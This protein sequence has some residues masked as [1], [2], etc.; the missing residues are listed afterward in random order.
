MLIVITLEIISYLI[1]YLKFGKEVA[2]HAIMSKIL[3]IILFIMLFQLIATGTSGFIFSLCIYVG[4]ITK[5]E[6]ILILLI[7]KT[8]TND[9]PGLY[10]AILKDHQAEKW[11]N[12]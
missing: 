11:F 1:S 2:T 7:L 12:G 6:I 10:H 3:A 8:W 9:V 4:I 5:V